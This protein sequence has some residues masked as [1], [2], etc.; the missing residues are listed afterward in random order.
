ML[1]PVLASAFKGD[2][3][4]QQRRGKDMTR[5]KILI[6]LLA[7]GRKIPSEYE[8]HPLQ[9]TWRG[10]RDA[11]IEGDWILIYKV[12]GNDLKLARTGTHQ[13]IFSSA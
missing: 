13:D 3:K 7:E 1:K 9:G 5:L 2:I 10:Y 8:D 4:R 11:H 6:T 12:V